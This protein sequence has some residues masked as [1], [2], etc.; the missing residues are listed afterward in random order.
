MRETMKNFVLVMMI[1]TMAIVM[2]LAQ[3]TPAH[4][5]ADSGPGVPIVKAFLASYNQPDLAS[6][7]NMV[8]EDIVFLDD[9]GHTNVGKTFLSA[10][11]QRRLGGPSREKLIASGPITSSGTDNVVWASFPYTFDRGD[12]HRKGL[13]TM[14]FRKIA[15]DWQIVHFQFAIDQVPARSLDR[16]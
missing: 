9:D 8:A 14:V 13:I 6:I 12:V 3:G 7:L 1:T 16:R 11:L 15:A 10:A 2:A 4:P 5:E